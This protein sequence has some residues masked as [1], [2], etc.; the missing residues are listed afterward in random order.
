MAIGKAENQQMGW[1]FDN[2]YPLVGFRVKG[3]IELFNIGGYNS[4]YGPGAMDLGSGWTTLGATRNGSD[5][6]FYVNDTLI[7]ETK[8]DVK[9]LEGELEIGGSSEF[10][11]SI[12]GHYRNLIVF[13]KALSGEEIGSVIAQLK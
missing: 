12:N 10:W 6:K 9:D 5:W 11:A 13:S 4:N 8:S 7:R 2:Y 1:H 3:Q